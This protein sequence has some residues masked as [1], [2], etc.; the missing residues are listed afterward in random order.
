VAVVCWAWRFVRRLQEDRAGRLAT[1]VAW[2]MLNTLLPAILGVLALAGVALVDAA[3]LRA[4]EDMLVQLLPA[5]AAATVQ[6][7]IERSRELAGITGLIS[8][9]LLLFN[10]SN[11]FTTLE[12]VFDLIYRV[13]ERP[14]VLK[15]LVGLGALL[16]CSGLLVALIVGS[17]VSATVGHLLVDITGWEGGSDATLATL[18]AFPAIAGWFYALYTVLP[19]VRLG[20]KHSIPGAM[21]AGALFLAILRLFPLYVSV[22]GGG[23]DLYS[24]FGSVLL[25][26]FWLY[27][28]GF[29]IVGGAELNAFLRPS[30]RGA[31]DAWLGPF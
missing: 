28:V 5:Q 16:F 20:W 18:L 4:A 11:L 30:S 19:N 12:S 24:A 3:Q 17:A 22:F 1:L 26:T 31:G 23:L 10:G 15:H 7:T 9:G 29:A 25:F 6:A 27:L 8:I 14:L 21:V 2:S 13:P